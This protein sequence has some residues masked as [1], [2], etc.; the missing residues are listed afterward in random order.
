MQPG[1]F[2]LGYL[3]LGRKASLTIGELSDI[4]AVAMLS[5]NAVIDA[6]FSKLEFRNNSAFPANSRL[7]LQG[8]VVDFPCTVQF[9]LPGSAVI[10][11]AGS[12]L[13]FD[14]LLI[15]TVTAIPPDSSAIFWLK[16]E[17][18]IAEFNDTDV[19]VRI[20][21]E[22]YFPQDY[23]L[24]IIGAKPTG[25]QVKGRVRLIN[26]QTLTRKLS[27]SNRL[28]LERKVST[29]A[30]S[31]AARTKASREAALLLDAM[32]PAAQVDPAGPEALTLSQ[33]DSITG[34]RLYDRKV[35]AFFDQKM[36][37]TS[38]H[39][40]Q[41]GDADGITRAVFIV[42]AVVFILLVK[43]LTDKFGPWSDSLF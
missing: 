22:L 16:D 10:L 8:S 6:M 18:A 23:P 43:C 5:E 35:L 3:K 4:R 36:P 24:T 20:K 27:L 11:T 17:G 38:A 32:I 30:Y 15:L 33:F 34:Q 19:E 31:D 39:E 1:N 13:H 29:T 28:L 21:P 40:T 14:G 42:A 9:D 7:Q 12:Q 41:R 2:D 37:E 25:Q 26:S